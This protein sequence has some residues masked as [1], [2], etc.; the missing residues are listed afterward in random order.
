MSYS[1]HVPV[2]EAWESLN[3]SKQIATAAH[4]QRLVFLAI[5]VECSQEATQAVVV[6]V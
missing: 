1:I 5:K 3:N 6:V 4:R 2:W